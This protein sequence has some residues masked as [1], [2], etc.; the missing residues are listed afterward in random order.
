MTQVGGVI[1]NVV[2]KHLI[3]WVTFISGLVEGTAFKPARAARIT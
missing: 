3:V 2:K 1:E